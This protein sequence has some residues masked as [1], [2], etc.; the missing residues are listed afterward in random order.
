MST[1]V[2]AEVNKK[3]FLDHRN[4]STFTWVKIVYCKIWAIGIPYK[5]EYIIQN[6]LEQM[7]QNQ[8]LPKCEG[9]IR[10]KWT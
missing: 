10:D 1:V 8:F 4:Y 7:K 3:W 6:V 2:G 9:G 5:Q